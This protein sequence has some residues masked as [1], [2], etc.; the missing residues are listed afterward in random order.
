[1]N[2]RLRTTRR[3]GCLLAALGF[4][5][6]CA[7]SPAPAPEA[8]RS[9]QRY[10]AVD[11]R[12]IAA[13]D[14]EPDQWLTPGRDGGGTYYSP[15]ADINDRNVSRLGFAWGYTL[16]TRRGLEATPVV[17]DGILYTSGNWGR[18]YALDAATGREIWTYDPKVDGQYGRHAPSDVVNRGVAVIDGRVY[19]GALDGFLHALDARTGAL[20]WKVDTLPER[21][22]TSFPYFITGAP[23]IAGD[24]IVIGNGG[25]DLAG[26]RGFITA[27]DRQTGTLRW[28]FY[29][30]PRDPAAGKQPEYLQKAVASWDADFNWKDGGGGAAWDGLSYDPALKLIYAGTGNASPYKVA[31]DPHG[32]KRDRLYTAAIVAVHAGSGELAWYFQPVNGD[33]WDYDN[34]QKMVLADLQVD[35]RTRQVLMQASKNGFFY[36]LDRATG[37]FLSGT[38]FATVTWTRGLDPVTHRPLPTAAAD[39]TDQPRLVFPGAYGGHNWQPMSYSAKSGLVYIPVIEAPMVYINTAQRPAGYV[40]YGFNTAIPFA[41]DYDPAALTSLLGKLPP[42]RSLKGEEKQ[43]TASRGLLRAFDPEHGK[44]AWEVPSFSMWDGG[45]LSTAGNIVVRGDAAGFLNVY[46]A[47]SGAP[48]KQIDVGTSIMAA[49]M[50]YRVNGTQYVA[51]MAGY[52][53][54]L[55]SNPFPAGSAAEKYGNAGRIVVFRLDGGATPKPE[56]LPALAAVNP[57]PRAGTDA[58]IARGEI[59]YNRFCARCHVLGRSVL[60]DLRRLDPPTHGLFKEI[61]LQGLYRAKGMARWDDVLTEA[62]AE[63]IHDYLIAQAWLLRDAPSSATVH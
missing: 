40:E 63:S 58:D 34:A 32:R 33:G 4:L 62:D 15:L 41:D 42:L 26:S 53:G 16:G 43:V 37:E 14:Q 9:P 2:T 36:V 6:C 10:G 54:G 44:I 12:R 52:G 19:V 46:A 28:R 35:G 39:W 59:L 3:I 57:P 56:P 13:A 8:A 31:R 38:P 1:M 49:P 22:P 51:V 45:I 7:R 11:E 18:V 55:I 47:D 27:F 48:L 60:P 21:T 61:V 20:V 30:V 23:L 50:T 5:A 25:A 29:V 24:L 17:V